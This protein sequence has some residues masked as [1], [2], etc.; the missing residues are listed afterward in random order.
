MTAAVIGKGSARN[1][2]FH[3]VYYFKTATE[4]DAMV[5]DAYSPVTKVTTADITFSIYSH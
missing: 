3:H 5:Y 4:W 2:D 1:S